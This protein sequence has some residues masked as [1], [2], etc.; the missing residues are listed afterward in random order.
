MDASLRITITAIDG[1]VAICAGI[2]HAR[3]CS[4]VYTTARYVGRAAA[5]SGPLVRVPQYAKAALI[6]RARDETMKEIRYILCVIIAGQI[7]YTAD[8]PARPRQNLVYHA[9][10]YEIRR[11]PLE[12][13][14]KNCNA[15]ERTYIWFGHDALRSEQIPLFGPRN[16]ETRPKPGKTINAALATRSSA[17]RSEFKEQCARIAL[18]AP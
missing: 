6:R 3:C 12:A 11:P 5:R 7:V 10:R 2:S 13:T 17:R 8:D 1:V 4:E 9:V 16:S 15:P 18:V 14:S